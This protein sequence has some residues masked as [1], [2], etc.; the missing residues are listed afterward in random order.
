[1]SES[2]RTETKED[3]LKKLADLKLELFKERATLVTKG[4]SKNTKAVRTIRKN[5]ARVLTSLEK[6]GS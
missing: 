4:G 3:L 6:R 1:M 5:I 2:S